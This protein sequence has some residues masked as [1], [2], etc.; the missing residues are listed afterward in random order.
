MEYFTV[1]LVG[2]LNSWLVK[3]IVGF[4]VLRFLCKIIWYTKLKREVNTGN[5]SDVVTMYSN[6]LMNNTVTKADDMYEMICLPYL[7]VRNDHIMVL[8]SKIS[9][10]KYS[11]SD[12]I[13]VFNEARLYGFKGIPD[14]LKPMINSADIRVEFDLLETFCTKEELPQAINNMAMAMV[15]AS[16]ILP[17][18]AKRK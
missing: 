10:G 16:Y 12:G 17:E 9:N 15:V 1:L 3:V 7:D 6:W 4:L 18:L 2:I 5:E 8:V 13:Y 14:E 11:V